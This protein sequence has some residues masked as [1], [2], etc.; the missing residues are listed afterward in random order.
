MYKGI[1]SITT[2]FR[3]LL[4]GHMD[5]KVT[6]EKDRLFV[7]GELQGLRAQMDLYGPAT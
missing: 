6:I 4:N 3:Q 5:M 7:R 1:G 2:A